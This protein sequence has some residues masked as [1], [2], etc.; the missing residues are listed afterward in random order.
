MAFSLFFNVNQDTGVG[1]GY[2]SAIDPLGTNA[3]I[4]AFNNSAG[5]I[6]LVVT[7]YAGLPPVEVDIPSFSDHLVSI[8]NIQTIGIL[9]I[10]SF[11]ISTFMEIWFSG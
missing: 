6:R 5:P 8:G 3:V 10:S 9:N 1:Q 7:R 4:R 11:P 2:Y